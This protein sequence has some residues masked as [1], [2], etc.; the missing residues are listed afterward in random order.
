MRFERAAF[1]PLPAQK[2]A[3]RKILQECATSELGA[4]FGLDRVRSVDDMRSL[5]PTDYDSIRDASDRVYAHGR[6][7]GAVFG[8][9]A[10]LAFAMSSGTSGAPKRFPVTAAWLAAYRRSMLTMNAALLETSGAYEH[11]LGGRRIF[12]AN[13]PYLETAPCGLPCGWMS[14]ILFERAPWAMRRAF[15]PSVETLK[16]PDWEKKI[17]RLL[18]EARHADVRVAVGFPAGLRSFTEIALSHFGVRTL[19]EVWPNL[20]A[21]FFGGSSFSTAGRDA[22]R[23]AWRG[24]DSKPF[25]SWENYSSTET[26]FGHAY[27]EDWPGL[28]FSPFES[29]YQFKTSPDDTRFYQLHELEEGGLYHVF[30]STQGGLVNYRMRDVVEITSRRPLTFR[31]SRRE[32]DQVTI[33]GE[34]ITSRDAATAH[35]TVMGPLGRGAEDYALYLE[36]GS[37]C[38]VVWVLPCRDDVA[39]LD[40]LDHALRNENTNYGSF[41]S[42]SFY[43]PPRAEIV[44]AS[45][46]HEY[47][48]RHLSRGTFKEKRIFQTRDAF[49]AECALGETFSGEPIQ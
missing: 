22:L 23:R 42:S 9:S 32:H 8:R 45:V 15:L 41:R 7:A 13:S 47:R 2:E 35:A 11:F 14:G 20:R 31:F 46:F 12:L 25:C 34:R 49:I 40:A 28:V 37:P 44:S 26:L 43:G 5:A 30:V 39:L 6:S 48:E 19:S 33:M 1:D 4:R 10:P 21:V 17:R 38:R 36:E 16:E 18:E 24:S 3:L 29:F 27:R